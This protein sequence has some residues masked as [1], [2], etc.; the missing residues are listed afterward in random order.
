MHRPRKIASKFNIEIRAI[1]AKYNKAG[2]PRRFIESVIRDFITPLD[3]DESL[4]IPPNMFAV[5]KPFLLL[6]IPYCEQNEIASKR[7]IKKFHQFTGDKYDIAI[8]WLTKKVKSPFTLKYRNLHPSC[9]IYK[10][11]CSCG[12]IYIGETIRNIEERWSEHNPADN[13]SE[14]AKHLAD[15]KEHSF[16]WSI[17]LAA[18]KDGRTR[19]TLDAFF[20]A[21]LKPFL[22]RQEDSNILTL[23]RNG[24]TYCHYSSAGQKLTLS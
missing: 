1:K 21:K 11:V 15:N 18:P 13:K 2:H 10:S 20:I 24:V 4:I 23:F 17:L 14:P 9:K 19:K 22:N 7:F 5:K 6:E 8:K 16:L 3:K 12:E